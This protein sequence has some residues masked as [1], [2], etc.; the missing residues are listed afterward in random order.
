MTEALPKTVADNFRFLMVECQ[1]QV[2][3]VRS[4]MEL[5]EM[6]PA[7]RVLDRSGYADNLK[8]RVRDGCLKAIRR[9]KKSG[10]KVLSLRAIEAVAIELDRITRLCRDCVQQLNGLG[11]A[12][13]E[14]RPRHAEMLGQIQIGLDLVEAALARRDVE[15]AVR[16]TKIREAV[17][18]IYMR[19]F[20]THNFEL[21][22]GTEP[23]PVVTGIIAAQ[24]I[25]EMGAALHEVGDALV[26]ANLGQ[27]LTAE[28]YNTLSQSVEQIRAQTKATDLTVKPLAQ[29]RS[30]SMISGISDAGADDERYIAVFKDGKRRKLIEERDKVAAWN[31]IFPGMA[32]KILAYNATQDSAA[33]LIE[34]LSGLTFEQILVREDMPLL[35]DALN[36]L[37]RTLRTV[38]QKTHTETAAP[39]NHMRQ[40][41]KRMDEV[42]A[43]H[44][45]FRNDG[46]TYG[47]LVLPSFDALIARCADLEAHLRSP[48]TVR[49]H[50]DFNVDN[51]IYDPA[52][53]TIRFI[54]LHRSTEM[55]YVQ[56]VAVFMVSNYRLQALDAERRRRANFVSTDFCKFA[57]AYARRVKDDTFDIRL[58]LALARSFATSTR[59]I[60]DQ[61]LVRK[62]FIRA[63][64]L[65]ERIA[66]ADPA[67]LDR[68]R[69]P[70]KELFFG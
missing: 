56:D 19:L 2:A 63:R 65:L 9:S 20:T 21:M 61:S 17:D 6:G 34:H 62:M 5:G 30:G 59:F 69:V 14:K 47:E 25:Q 37:K 53:K 60:L 1:A 8:M 68:F 43:V 22:K 52:D 40:L 29:T 51:I 16:V 50:G 23:V 36:E 45:R 18:A 44:G 58:A 11:R 55:D 66:E 7:L 48:Y 49:I 57:R 15:T 41:A 13:A 33:L 4:A 3:D 32:P 46:V 31:A 42:Y 67:R 26:S 54:D 39:A 38:W 24:R 35:V 28:R 27:A 10:T 64:Y 12:S 70:T